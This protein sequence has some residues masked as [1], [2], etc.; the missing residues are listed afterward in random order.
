MPSPRGGADG[1]AT[2]VAVGGDL[3][4]LRGNPDPALPLLR[5]VPAHAPLEYVAGPELVPDLL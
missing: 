2:G 3:D 1:V 4:E 5:F